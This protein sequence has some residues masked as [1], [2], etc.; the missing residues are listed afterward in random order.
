MYILQDFNVTSFLLHQFNIYYLHTEILVVNDLT[1]D[2]FIR[3]ATS[4][5][6]QIWRYFC[7]RVILLRFRNI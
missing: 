2:S 7:D 1:T 4:R 6:V 3:N 5:V